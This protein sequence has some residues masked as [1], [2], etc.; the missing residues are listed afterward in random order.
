MSTDFK[1]LTLPPGVVA[2]AT[3]KMQSTNYSEVNMVRWV[4]G[5]LAP[6]G[7]QTRYAFTFASRCKAVHGW[8]DLLQVYNVAYLC[9]SNLYVDRGGILLDISPAVPIVPPTPP[10]VGGY[11]DG[12]YKQVRPT[13]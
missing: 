11:G 9:E 4:E 2:T 1:P 13:T 10:S 6:I 8:Y 12:A 5:Q 3:K 7:G